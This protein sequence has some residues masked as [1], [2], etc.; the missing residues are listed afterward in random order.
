MH[1]FSVGT[2]ES[3]R[4]CARGRAHDTTIH[5]GVNGGKTFAG[6][7]PEL[8]SRSGSGS[9]PGPLRLDFVMH[10]RARAI[11][12]ATTPSICRRLVNALN[13]RATSA[14]GSLA[15]SSYGCGRRST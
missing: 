9:G 7:N 1:V 2:W 3:D 14:P 5:V 13:G 8:P 11:I 12:L 4:A 6:Q 10:V 15:T